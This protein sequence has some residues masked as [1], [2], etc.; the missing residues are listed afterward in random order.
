MVKERKFTSIK[1]KVRRVILIAAQTALVIGSLVGLISLTWVQMMAINSEKQLAQLAS[2]KSSSAMLKLTDESMQ[3]LAASKAETAQSS[4]REYSSYVDGVTIYLERLYDHNIQDP[5]T[6]LLPRYQYEDNVETLWY[7]YRDG[8][9][10]KEACMEEISVVYPVQKMLAST[11]KNNSDVIGHIYYAS[12]SGFM[13]GYD[14]MPTLVKEY[15]DYTQRDWYVNAKNSGEVSYTNPEIDAFGTGTMITVSSPVYA[16]GEFKG[17]VAIDIT[18]RKLLSTITDIGMGNGAYV[19]L[20]DQGGNIIASPTV[21]SNTMEFENILSDVN[22][23]DYDLGT[24]MANGKSGSVLVNNVYYYFAPIKTNGWWVVIHADPDQIKAPIKAMT[25]DISNSSNELVQSLKFLVVNIAIVFVLNFILTALIS[26][27]IAK[28][29]GGEI[30]EPLIQMKEGV[31]NLGYKQMHIEVDTDDEVGSLAHAFNNMQDNLIKYIDDLK[32]MTAEKERIGA[33]LDVATRIQENML[34]N[35]FPYRPDREEF[36]L[37]ASMTPAKEVGGDFYDFFMVDDTHL[38]LV[39]ADVSGKGV[40]AALFMVITKTLIKNAVLQKM[41]A[42]QVAETVNAQLYETNKEG[43]FVTVWLG[44]FDLT[45]GKMDCVN[46]GHEYPAIKR[47]D[48][49]FELFQDKHCFVMAG[50]ED[51]IFKQYELQLYPGDRLFVYTDGVPEATNANQELFGN[52][53][54]VRALNEATGDCRS[55][56]DTVNDAIGTF[57]GDAEQFDD[58]TMLCMHYNHP[59]DKK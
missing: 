29:L 3:A 44:I 33:E 39:I 40:P 56:I 37:Y 43:M 58:I 32:D 17:V 9:V 46:A 11:F 27:W 55:V 48:G 53:R 19:L 14:N 38:A 35:I 30:T 45:T 52:D 23:A 26:V 10:D 15:F 28:K 5:E 54:M 2:D 22:Y 6:F 36:D 18:L 49:Y 34:P 57:V 7:S 24:L 8:N 21:D 51:S 12:E 31:E 47:K 20:I 1:V 59:Y 42:S 25:A 41:T 50:F 13:I 4:M 16:N